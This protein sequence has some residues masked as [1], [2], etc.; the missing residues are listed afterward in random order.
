MTHLVRF[1]RVRIV[2]SR[3]SPQVHRMKDFLARNQIAYEW[4]DIDRNATAR[5][6]LAEQGLTSHD[7]P[8]VIFPNGRHLVRPSN[9]EISA[10]L[11]MPTHT[12]TTS[13]DV[14]IVGGGPAGLATAIYASSEGLHTALIER[15]ALG[16]QAGTSPRIDNYLGFPEGLSGGDL[17]RRAATQAHRFGVDMLVPRA[18][19]GIQPADTAHSIRL[20]DGSTLHGR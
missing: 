4:L 13:Y 6:A 10:T 19:T 8:V 17:A 2:G 18:V 1:P 7:L 20:D 14:V 5:Q 15:E 12:Q 16:G 3:W 9:V 11:G